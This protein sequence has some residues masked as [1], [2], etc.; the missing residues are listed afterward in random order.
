MKSKDIK[1]LPESTEKTGSVGTDQGKRKLLRGLAVTAP[2]IMAVSSK[3]ALANFCTVS[4][5]LSGNL[6]NPNSEK[7]CGGRSPGYWINHV[8]PE[9]KSMTFQALFGGLWEGKSGKWVKDPTLYEVLKM[10]GHEDRYE[11]GAHAVAVYQ[12][13]LLISGY[14]MSVAEV[15]DIVSQILTYGIYTHGGTGK[16]LDAQQVVDFFTQTFD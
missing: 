10:K 6:S 13:A 15:G 8:T 1:K 4:G 5:F 2:V 11:F 7:R 16:T 9:L 12:N 3:P 14:P